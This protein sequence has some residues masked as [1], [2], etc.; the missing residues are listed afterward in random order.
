MFG[1]NRRNYLFFF[2]YSRTQENLLIY[3]IFIK[4]NLIKKGTNVRGKWHFPIIL[5]L[6][7]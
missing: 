4:I 1:A 7:N 3:S 5:Y 2:N 6:F